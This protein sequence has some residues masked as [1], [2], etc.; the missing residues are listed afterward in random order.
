MDFDLERFGGV[1]NGGIRAWFLI[2]LI[3]INVFKC[4]INSN[5]SHMLLRVNRYV[6]HKVERL[7]V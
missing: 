1:T 5:V 7:G 6:P 4:F 3:S 2:M